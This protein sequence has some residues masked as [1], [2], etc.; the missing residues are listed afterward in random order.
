MFISSILIDDF[1][2]I[3]LI[4]LYYSKNRGCW[5]DGNLTAGNIKK[6]I[7]IFGVAGSWQGWVDN[8]IQWNVIGAPVAIRNTGEYDIT[9]NTYTPTNVIP[10]QLEFREDLWH[11]L[12]NLGMNYIC[13]DCTVNVYSVHTAFQNSGCARPWF[14][15][16]A[17][18]SVW[19][20]MNRWSSYYDRVSGVHGRN[21][22][23]SV[24]TFS[25]KD[26][27]NNSN[28][29]NGYGSDV[30]TSGKYNIKDMGDYFLSDEPVARKYFKMWVSFTI[31]CFERCAGKLN[32]KSINVWFSKS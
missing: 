1:N 16:Y 9:G 25:Y 19:D 24:T 21:S 28:Y 8:T 4:Q 18:G 20:D 30:K 23:S 29:E 15:C 6:G 32:Y 2:K 5:G 27:S 31:H 11:K 13:Y 12:I 3:N 10:F 14:L 22:S 26:L 17:K 7:S